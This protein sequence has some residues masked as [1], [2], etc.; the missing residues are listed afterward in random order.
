[1]PIATKTWTDK[2]E[3]NALIDWNLDQLEYHIQALAN[4]WCWSC[5]TRYHVE[6][7]AMKWHAKKITEFQAW[8]A[9]ND[10]V[11]EDE[12]YRGECG[13]WANY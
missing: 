4:N 8:L 6:G 5:I 13:G 2:D 3:H 10:T 12:N 11:D 9:I 7:G 1:M